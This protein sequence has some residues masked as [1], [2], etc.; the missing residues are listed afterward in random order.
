MANSNFSVSGNKAQI[1]AA[2]DASN[3]SDPTKAYIK[4]LVAGF[5]GGNAFSVAASAQD[6]AT[7][8][9]LN[10]TVMSTPQRL[11]V[12]MAPVRPIE[13]RPTEANES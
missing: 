10:I 7:M 1:E 5:P 8:A 4:G 11:T 13:A 9:A 2:I 12:P 6:E 3:F